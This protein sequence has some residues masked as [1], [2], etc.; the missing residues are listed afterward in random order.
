MASNHSSLQDI[1]IPAEYRYIAFFELLADAILQHREASRTTESFMMNRFARASILASALSVECAANCLLISLDTSKKLS[2]ELDRMSPLSKIEM[3][4]RLNSKPALDRG[5]IKVSK[6]ADLISA[7]NDFV[8]PKVKGLS[9]TMSMPRD[10]GEEWMF[11][12]SIDGAHHLQLPIPK[13]PLFWSATNSLA[14]LVAVADF[15]RYL[16]CTLL[17]AN[18]EIMHNMLISRVEAGNVHIPAVYDELRVIL[19]SV[20]D[21]GVD[22]SYFGLSQ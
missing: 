18:Q 15:F 14:T 1:S 9:A 10:A 5:D 16:F 22:F 4:L 12:F 21:L 2:D 7:R 8:H 20:K 3:Y 6:I 13:V 11:P 17:S 19:Q